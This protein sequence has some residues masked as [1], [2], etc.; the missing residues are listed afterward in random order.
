MRVDCEPDEPQSFQALS[1][2]GTALLL[3]HRDADGGTLLRWSEQEVL[4]LPLGRMLGLSHDG[5]SIL[6]ADRKEGVEKFVVT[7]ELQSEDH[8]GRDPLPPGQVWTISPGGQ[9]DASG[10]Y[11]AL[12]EP[13]VTTG[14]PSGRGRGAQIPAVPGCT[15]PKRWCKLNSGDW[16]T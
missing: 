2:D 9:D 11:R 1:S 14:S 16:S 10:L 15:E 8:V 13:P 5:G 12:G 6:C 4:N 3:A 7:P